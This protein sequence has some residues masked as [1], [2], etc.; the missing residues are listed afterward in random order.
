M[1]KRGVEK[2]RELVM[3]SGEVEEKLWDCIRDVEGGQRK[4]EKSEIYT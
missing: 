4:E 2:G 3:G 1:Q